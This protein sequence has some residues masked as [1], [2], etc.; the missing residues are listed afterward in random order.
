MKLGIIHLSDLHFRQ[1]NFDLDRD[2]EMAKTIF[3][4]VRTDLIGTT[5]VFLIIS[6][7]LAYAGRAEE[8][9]YA[10]D[11]LLELFTL[12]DDGCSATCR[13]VCCPGNHDVDHRDQRKLRAALVEKI[14]QDPEFSL[15]RDVVGECVKEQMEFFKFRNN[16]EGDEIL[17]H[18][19][20][21]LRIYRIRDESSTVQI[22]AFN[23]AW[24]SSKEENPGSLVFPIDAYRERL[25][26]PDGF[27]ISVLHHPLAWFT[28]ESSRDLRSEL[29]SCSSVLLFGH[30][31]MPDG[32]RLLTKLGDHV[33][34]V[35]GGVLDGHMTKQN[36][37]NLLL[38]DTNTSQI[39]H[40]TYR[41]VGKRYEYANHA[42]WQDASRL[43]SSESGRFRLK[44]DQRAWLE[45][46]GANILHPRQDKI[47]LR[48]IFVYP[49][50]LPVKVD[51]IDDDD[52]LERTI[53]AESLIFELDSCHVLV[54]GEENSGKTALL[55]MFF[56][57]YYQRGK[58]PLYI[59]ANKISSRKVQGVRN[60]IQR[61]FSTTYE[62]GDF[63]EFEQLNPDDRVLLIDD[64]EFGDGDLVIW[65]E[66]FE[67]TQSFACRSVIVTRD[68]F[69]VERY[70]TSRKGTDVLRG[71]QAYFIE[72]FG[73]VRRD[74]L[75]KRWIL[76]G[77]QSSDWNSIGTL[78]ERDQMRLVINTTIG[79]SLVPSLPLFL[80]VI[81]QSTETAV[82]SPI[83][84]TYGHYYQFLITRTLLKSGVRPQD[85]DAYSNYLSEFA[86]FELFAARKLQVTAN[87]F[88]KWHEGF[89]NKFGVGWQAERIKSRLQQG[90]IFLVEA[91]GAVS[92]RYQYIYYFFLSK[93]LAGTIS[94]EETRVIVR[95]MCDRLHVVEYSN[96]VLF[97]IHHSNDKFV[98]D[99]IRGSADGLLKD[100]QPFSFAMSAE[101]NL[102]E[103]INKLSAPVGPQLLEERD[104][105]TEQR[106]LLE[107]RDALEAK[108]SDIEQQG[109]EESDVEEDTTWALDSLAQAGVATKTVELVGQ[110]LR[111][112]YGSLEISTKVRLGRDAMDLG[113]RALFTFFEMVITED[114]EVLDILM[115]M[116]RKYERDN[117]KETARRNEEELKRWARDCAF[118]LVRVVARVMVRKIA[119]ALGTEEMKPTLE[120]L[121]PEDASLA[122]KMVKVAALL[123]GPSDIPKQEIVKISRELRNN[124]LGFHVLRDL[125]AQRVYRYPIEYKDKQWLV[126][127]LSFSIVKQRTADLDKTRRLLAG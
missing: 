113:F 10:E 15:D 14:R 120:A 89:C 97:L 67:F 69:S 119:G 85:L 83:G 29:T 105:D 99:C 34:I 63:T 12:I 49:D 6:G 31:H 17:V 30:E 71:F 93:R 38:L 45:D 53:S 102:L 80:V 47:R 16:L 116:R 90:K 20:A 92:F 61:V 48:D 3:S 118:S 36:S 43:T 52:R 111:N 13:I 5:H 55:R 8:Y 124:S 46:M 112:Y 100:Q 123:D 121:V 27:A 57:E 33:R 2:N 23:T 91:S 19:D 4:A 74:E 65:K 32:T 106:E 59:P 108:E 11:W 107:Q 64:F 94:T 51:A 1:N 114:L 78:R 35:D 24:M 95:N 104:P 41:Q 25:Q 96:T 28:T 54:E 76:L 98:L 39:K 127:K 81:L 79:K 60:T 122:Y 37:F 82:Q 109:S 44:S 87:E 58:I 115:E 22:N 110:L 26:E 125:V 18:D 7:D 72:E 50:L 40:N 9:E 103:T 73:H 75:I 126:D 21:L 117:V 101:N 70:A 62:G 77:R 42:D 86:Y 66:L 88:A 68:L 56:W 84:S